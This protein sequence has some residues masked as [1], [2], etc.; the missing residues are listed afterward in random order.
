MG[1]LHPPITG[2]TEVKFI[3][4]LLSPQMCAQNRYESKLQSWEFCWKF[5]QVSD[6]EVAFEL[7]VQACYLNTE[8][9]GFFLKQMSWKKWKLGGKLGFCACQKVNEDLA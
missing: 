4:N 6:A 9:Y 3:S 5:L 1:K 2:A 8:V 7:I